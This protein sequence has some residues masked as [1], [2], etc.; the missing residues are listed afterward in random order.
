MTDKLERPDLEQRAREMLAAE[1]AAGGFTDF[2]A[3][4]DSYLAQCAKRTITKA[5]ASVPDRQWQDIETAPKDGTRILA[6][7]RYRPE[8]PHAGSASHEVVRWCGWW[9]S[10][11]GLTRP[12]PTHWMPLPPPPAQD[13]GAS[14]EDG[15]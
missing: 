10:S 1:Y 9:D 7:W 2:Y 6:I 13:R 4:E 8:D 12:E 5:L 11:D 3:A 14:Q 15:G